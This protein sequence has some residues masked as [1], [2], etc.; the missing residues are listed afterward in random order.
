MLKKKA[1]VPSIVIN[2]PS[3]FHLSIMARPINI[4]RC[5]AIV[6]HTETGGKASLECRNH[7]KRC[8]QKNAPQN[9]KISNAK[10]CAIHRK[11]PATLM[12]VFIFS[13]ISFIE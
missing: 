3:L 10:I 1:T 2:A 9:K 4:T 5:K 12:L 11:V 6:N 7:S 8:S 13:P